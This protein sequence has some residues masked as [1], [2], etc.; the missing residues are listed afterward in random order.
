MINYKLGNKYDGQST[1]VLDMDCLPLGVSFQPTLS[2]DSEDFYFQQ[3][4]QIF[5]SLCGNQ[6]VELHENKD[7]VEGVKHVFCFMH[8]FEDPFAVCWRR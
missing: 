1:S 8:V 3:S 6:Q 7:A 4:Q 2:F 5:Q